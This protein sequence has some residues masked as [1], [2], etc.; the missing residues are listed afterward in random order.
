MV[1]HIAPEAALGGGLA[2]VRDGDIVSIDVA[3]RR[4]DVDLEDAEIAARLAAWKP[5]TPRYPTGVFAKYAA[6]VSS[7]SLG[8][9][10]GR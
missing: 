9:V 1:A 8:A 5:P 10:T 2:A 7:A 6:S 3:A 4:I